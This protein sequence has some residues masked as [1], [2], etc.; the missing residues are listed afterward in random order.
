VNAARSPTSKYAAMVTILC[1]ALAATAATE[2]QVNQGT[3][4][5]DS[6]THKEDEK[7]LYA[8]RRNV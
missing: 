7:K 6:L 5:S 8:R 2:G 3:I 4:E 1:A